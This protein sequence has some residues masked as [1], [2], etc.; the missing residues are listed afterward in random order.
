MNST[1]SRLRAPLILVLVAAV[2]LAVGGA[3]HGWTTLFAVPAGCPR[4][5]RRPRP[6]RHGRRQ[7]MS[8]P[9]SCNQ[10]DDAPGQP[11]FGLACKASSWVGRL[12]LAV[13]VAYFVAAATGAAFV[14]LRTVDRAGVGRGVVP[15]RLGDVR[16]T[17]QAVGWLD[18]PAPGRLTR[19]GATARPPG[20]PRPAGSGATI[21][22]LRGRV[23]DTDLGQRVTRLRPFGREVGRA[24]AWMRMMGAESVAYHRET[25]MGRADDHRGAAWAITRRR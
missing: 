23:A 4:R 22:P 21:H 11:K 19:R 1:K 13:A 8:G 7:R 12:S 10:L 2:P 17:R 16:R 14:A 20:A 5:R 25:V 24:L 15:R 3:T 9:S 6:R 18:R